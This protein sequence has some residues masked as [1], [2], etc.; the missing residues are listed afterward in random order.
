MVKQFFEEVARSLDDLE[1]TTSVVLLIPREQTV[2]A[3]LL[4]NKNE[5]MTPVAIW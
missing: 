1:G 5:Q 2:F 3:A 4:N